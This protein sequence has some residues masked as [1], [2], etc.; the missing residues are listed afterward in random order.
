MRTTGLRGPVGDNGEKIQAYRPPKKRATAKE[1]VG[2][3][4]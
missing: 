4:E 2:M 3:L 1:G